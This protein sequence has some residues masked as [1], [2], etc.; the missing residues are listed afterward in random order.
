M[1]EEPPPHAAT[2]RRTRD[3]YGLLALAIYL[4]FSLFIFGRPLLGHLRDTHIAMGGDVSL[5]TWFLVWWPYALA[6]RL[7]PLFT[8]LL[9]AP[10]GLN[11]AW[12]TSIPLPSLL[13]WP[14]TATL[15]PVAAFNV[16]C[17]TSLPL[18][19]WSGFILC[20]YICQA[21]WPSLLGGYIFGF[22]A[23]MLGQQGHPMMTIAVLV[24]LAVVMV[25]RAIAGELAPRRLV[26]ALAVILV[27]QFLISI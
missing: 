7:N 20:H 12:T 15:G 19:G 8:D 13:V 4:T 9:W 10:S 17:L 1:A 21:W 3:P 27:A 14:I 5:F 24:P 23:Y 2:W 25:L 11:L 18:S 16:L 22:S 26:V 6:H